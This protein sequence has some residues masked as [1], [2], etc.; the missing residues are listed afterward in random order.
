[1]T[2]TFHLLMLNLNF[3]FFTVANPVPQGLKSGNLLNLSA[4][5]FS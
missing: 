2:F 1:M 5:C 3:L 4:V